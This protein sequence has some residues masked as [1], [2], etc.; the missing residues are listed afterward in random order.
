MNSPNDGNGHGQQGTKNSPGGA[1][2]PPGEARRHHPLRNATIPTPNPTQATAP[3]Q[4]GNAS[5]SGYRDRSDAYAV[6]ILRRR[7]RSPSLSHGQGAQQ[8]DDAIP[9]HAP[10]T[11][12]PEGLFIPNSH[13]QLARG[14]SSP[15]SIPIVKV[16]PAAAAP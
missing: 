15:E 5:S 9:D 11:S 13:A 14:G 10:T 12:S 8:T 7:S 1:K 4:P 16:A 3:H 2:S 6:G